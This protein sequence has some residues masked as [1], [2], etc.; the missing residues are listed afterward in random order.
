MSAQAACILG[1]VLLSW[2][3]RSFLTSLSSTALVLSLDD[4]LALAAPVPQGTPQMGSRP[5]Y[6]AK[7][8][9]APTRLPSSVTGTPLD[10]SFVDVARQSGLNTKTIYGGEHKNRYL[11]ETTGCGVEEPAPCVPSGLILA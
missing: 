3:R 8:Q 1:S 10:V 4:V 9:P 6:D 2:S 5:T 7:P 11:I